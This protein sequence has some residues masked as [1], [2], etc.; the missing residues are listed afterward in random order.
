MTEQDAIAAF[1]ALSQVHRLRIVRRLV[2]A[3]T[4]GLSAGALAEAVGISP[5]NVSF[6]LSHLER[7]GLIQSRRESR[8]ILYSLTFSALSGLVGFLM[9]DCCDSHPEICLPNSVF[10][11]KPKRKAHV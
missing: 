10:N 8:S 1:G 11:C 7:A 6:H 5:S 3:G 9:N 2:K 4:D